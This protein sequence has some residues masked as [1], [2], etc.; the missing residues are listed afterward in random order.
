MKVG[1]LIKD[2]HSFLKGIVIDEGLK[3]NML[4]I[5]EPHYMVYWF[6]PVGEMKLS[7]HRTWRLVEDLVMISE[8]R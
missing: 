7:R 1:D 4:E 6:Q 8:S 2:P 3:M 5:P